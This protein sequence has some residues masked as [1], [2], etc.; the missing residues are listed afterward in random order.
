MTVSPKQLLQ[1]AALHSDVGCEGWPLASSFLEIADAFK[2]E[3]R[4]LSRQGSS[5]QNKQRISGRRVNLKLGLV[6]WSKSVLY[7]ISVIRPQ[8]TALNLNK[9]R[10]GHFFSLEKGFPLL[11]KNTMQKCPEKFYIS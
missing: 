6:V 5:T 9:F 1:C 4:G 2:C 3:P 8:H 11:Q 10:T 7:Q